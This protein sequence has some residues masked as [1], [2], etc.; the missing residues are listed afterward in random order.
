MPVLSRAEVQIPSDWLLQERPGLPRDGVRESLLW[1]DRSSPLSVCA[2]RSS[3]GAYR[4]RL[5]AEI[6]VDLFPPRRLVASIGRGTSRTSLRHFI[7]DQVIPR[8]IAGEG[9]LVLHAGAVKHETGALLF[10]GP[11]GAGKSTLTAGFHVN[12]YSLL[13]D[14]SIIVSWPF[15]RA[16]ATAV[17]PSL[18]L[19]PDSLSTLM[20]TAV[21]APVGEHTSKRSVPF[22]DG[23]QSSASVPVDAIF[24][25]SAAP[26]SFIECN[27]LGAADA[28][29]ALVQNSFALNP[30]D[31]RGAAI[32][33]KQAAELARTVPTFELRFPRTYQ[34]LPKVRSAVLQIMGTANWEKAA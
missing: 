7:T 3:T 22:T 8:A 19:F 27:I 17:Y 15:E 2:L 13:G 33:M 25:L 5:G 30:S 24:V 20:P 12:G 11:S 14:D 32:R 10:V 9:N 34:D 31:R 28:C 23:G 1:K 16:E 29:M 6:A 18:R 21:S 26:L 4:L